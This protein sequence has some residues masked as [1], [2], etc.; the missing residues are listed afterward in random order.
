MNASAYHQNVEPIGAKRRE[1]TPHGSGAAAQPLAQD[2][3]APGAD[4][5]AVASGRRRHLN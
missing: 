3:R 2:V 4:A 5:S 1:I